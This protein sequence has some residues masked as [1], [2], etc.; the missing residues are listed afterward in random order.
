MPQIDSPAVEYSGLAS[1]PTLSR[2]Q[3][4]QG[5]SH[6]RYLALRN[7]L[8]SIFIAAQQRRGPEHL[9]LSN[10]CLQSETG[11]AIQEENRNEE[12]LQ[13]ADLRSKVASK[14]H[15]KGKDDISPAATRQ[16]IL[17][18]YRAKMSVTRATFS[19]PN[20]DH[21]SLNGLPQQPI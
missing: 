5:N 10:V 19:G 4:L 14:S 15:S 17:A 1:H 2:K 9:N 6:S 11:N 12:S 13:C 18:V 7:E 20:S 8:E 16:S 21:A 3:I